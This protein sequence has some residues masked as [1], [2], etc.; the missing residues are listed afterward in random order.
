VPVHDIDSALALNTNGS[1]VDTV[2][3]GG[4]I[5]MRNRQVLV[6]DEAALLDESRFAVGRLRKRVGIN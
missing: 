2:I 5:L 3:V 1:H 6:L 4:N